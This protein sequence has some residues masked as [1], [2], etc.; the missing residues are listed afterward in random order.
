M[1]E[2]NLLRNSLSDTYWRMNNLYYVLDVNGNKVKFRFNPVQEYI[3]REQWYKTV[4][5]KSRQHGVTTYMAIKYLDACLFIPNQAA[6]II[7]QTENDARKIFDTKIKFAYE[8]L[9][10][11]LR[12]AVK[13]T[14]NRVDTMEFS[15]GS[16]IYVDCSFRG[17][18]LNLLH[19]SEF[20][21]ICNQFPGRA[22]E[23]ISGALNTVHQGNFVTIEST[24]EG[25]DG[26][27]Y[28]M[29]MDAQKLLMS[30]LKPNKMQY[31]FLFFG[32]YCDDKTT[33]DVDG[34]VITKEDEDLFR[35]KEIEVKRLSDCGV[36]MP[37]PGGRL[38]DGQK[39]WY[40]NKRVEQK[41]NMT[42]QYPFDPE[43]SFSSSGDGKYFRHEFLYLYENKRITNVPWEPG[44]PVNVG[45]DLGLDNYM[46]LIFHQTVLK[47]QRIIRTY[48]GYGKNLSHYV[49]YILRQG[50]V[51]GTN[52]LP[53]D[54]AHR[55][56]GLTEDIKTIQDMLRD[57]GI[58]KTH[59]VSRTN[60]KV[61]AIETAGNFLKTCWI[62]QTNC[63]D[64]IV[65]WTNY[66]RKQASNGRFLD[67][68]FKDDKG[69]NDAADALICLACGLEG[70]RE[71]P[72]G[73][74]RERPSNAAFY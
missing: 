48:Q 74:K 26:H 8:N 22:N 30:G 62:D 20:G 44:V 34:V 46:S 4:I 61:A 17:G 29:C 3:W 15:N 24:A 21:K 2:I 38:T 55:R 64:G 73:K 31:R 68:P 13:D 56:I 11:E 47:E 33:T 1:G 7:A 43:E 12:D 25:E 65:A 57:L 32:W 27:F 54:A 49:D 14:V 45:W 51:L 50:Y 28:E 69:Y 19:I 52:F 41:D 71:R 58:K 35:E 16:S 36:V 5:L 10:V 70:T 63:A 67:S 42:S 23:I 9:P 39:A 40:V 18:T 60:D 59:L 6:G 37:I 66:K 72:K 53:H